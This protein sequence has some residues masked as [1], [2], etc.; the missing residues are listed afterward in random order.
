M[1]IAQFRDTVS[2]YTHIR[3]QEGAKYRAPTDV[4]ITEWLEV[5]FVEIPNAI[6]AATAAEVARGEA[7]S[8]L[9]TYNDSLICDKSSV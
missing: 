5:Q 2:A 7:A 9:K 3:T 4:Q 8:I 1:K 6:D